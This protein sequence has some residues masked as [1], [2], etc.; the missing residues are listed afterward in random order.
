[1]ET[2]TACA[3]RSLKRLVPS[4]VILRT[5]EKTC[6]FAQVN[7]LCMSRNTLHKERH[8][9]WQ[10]QRDAIDAFHPSL[11]HPLLE[12]GPHAPRLQ[13]VLDAAAASSRG[14][15]CASVLEAHHQSSAIGMVAITGLLG[16]GGGGEAGFPHGSQDIVFDGHEKH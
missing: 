10:L 2:G 13:Q 15:I 6:F 16:G 11:D 9:H 1:M 8:L 5:G 3:L 12:A 14:A 7:L 4:L